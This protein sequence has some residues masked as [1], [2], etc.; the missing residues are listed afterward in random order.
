MDIVDY[1][2]G[3]SVVK[4]FFSDAEKN[5]LFRLIHSR[6]NDDS[7]DLLN[8]GC[9]Q[10]LPMLFRRIPAI[11][12]SL[13]NDK[14]LRALVK[15]SGINEQDL[16]VSDYSDF[17]INILGGWHNDIESGDYC[18][19]E[20]ARD[21]NILK[22]GIFFAEAIRLK[23]LITQFEFQ[24]NV[25]IPDVSARDLL[26]F[27]TWI[28]HRGYPGTRIGGLIRKILNRFNVPLSVHNSFY[29]YF[30][31]AHRESIFF[32]FGIK[33]EVFDRFCAENTKRALR[34]TSH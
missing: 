28:K 27:P 22:V 12:K 10:A 1:P 18:T 25:F 9:G 31:E 11:Q 3:V 30:G 33:G 5:D 32:T 24:G 13:I 4:D 15:A 14:M 2:G 21:G 29:R 34:Q 16:A 20:E 7:I 6:I 17:H 19:M 8:F 26:I 23:N